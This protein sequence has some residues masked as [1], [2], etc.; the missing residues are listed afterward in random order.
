MV[1]TLTEHSVFKDNND[2]ANALQKREQLFKEIN[3]GYKEPIDR[4]V[5]KKSIEERNKIYS[6]KTAW[7]KAMIECFPDSLIRKQYNNP[8][9][10]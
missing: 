8:L 7:K 1:T 5:F 9:C 3:K 10:K 6:M 4:S 2:I